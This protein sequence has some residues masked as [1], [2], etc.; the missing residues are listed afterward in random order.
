MTKVRVHV[1]VRD[2]HQ[3]LP[4][5]PRR[6]FRS[7]L[8]GLEKDRGDIQPLEGKLTGYYRLRIGAYRVILTYRMENGTRWAICL[9][10]EHRSLIYTLLEKQEALRALLND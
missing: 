4:P 1:R 9:F 2:F 5:A 8:R 10:A 6:K 7:A 3:A